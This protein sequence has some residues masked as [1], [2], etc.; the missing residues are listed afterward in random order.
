[1]HIVESAQSDCSSVFIFLLAGLFQKLL[2]VGMAAYIH[3]SSSFS[4]CAV[5]GLK[6]HQLTDACSV[7][8]SLC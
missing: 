1:M 3:P 8:L 7:T 5:F 4:F 6:S 2:V